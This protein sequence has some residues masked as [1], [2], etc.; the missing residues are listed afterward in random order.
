MSSR[1]REGGAGA[2]KMGRVIFSGN[3]DRSRY[4]AD[5]SGLLEEAAVED[6]ERSIPIW[7]LRQMYREFIS[8]YYSNLL[9]ASTFRVL[10]V[11]PIPL[12]DAF[13]RDA[14]NDFDFVRDIGFHYFD[15]ERRINILLI[16]PGMYPG[17]LIKS[18]KVK[19][20]KSTGMLVETIS[21]PVSFDGGDVIP[22]L[23]NEAGVEKLVFLFGSSFGDHF[24]PLKNQCFKANPAADDRVGIPEWG[25]AAAL[26]ELNESLAPKGIEAYHLPVKPELLHIFYHLD[27]HMMRHDKRLIV[28]NAEFFTPKAIALLKRLKIAVVDLAYDPTSE[29]LADYR[30]QLESFVRIYS[31]EEAVE[32]EFR[33]TLSKIKEVFEAMLADSANKGQH[34][35]RLIQ[36]LS[37]ELVTWGRVVKQAEGESSCVKVVYAL[38]L[39]ALYCENFPLDGQLELYLPG[40]NGVFVKKTFIVPELSRALHKKLSV[41]LRGVRIVMPSVFDSQSPFYQR[42]FSARVAAVLKKNY[43]CKSATTENLLASFQLPV[44]I[45][46]FLAAA[47]FLGLDPFKPNPGHLFLGKG[48]DSGLHCMTLDVVMPGQKLGAVPVKR[49]QLGMGSLLLKRAAQAGVVVE[50]R[51]TRK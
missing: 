1:I 20:A 33:T 42:D 24:I 27:M 16:H 11:M 22:V 31:G 5:L 46:H 15:R 9:L 32:V 25:V 40:I 7:R 36:L 23:V 47:S 14:G 50:A 18:M 44:V 17:C 10:G 19:I 12:Q 35:E 39:V 28:M 26:K 41:A 48:R 37:L 2:A 51:S 34:A 38:W 3:V 43:G 49:S 13:S 21:V 30:V 45:D 8:V 29:M 6:A 4:R